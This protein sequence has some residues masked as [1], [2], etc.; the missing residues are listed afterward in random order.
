MEIKLYQDIFE[1]FHLTLSPNKNYFIQSHGKIA[2]FET[3]AIYPMPSYKV[4]DPIVEY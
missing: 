2:L 1:V 3:Q 4:F